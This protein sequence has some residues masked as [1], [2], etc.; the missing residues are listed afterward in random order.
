MVSVLFLSF[1]VN[2]PHVWQ[3]EFYVNYVIFEVTEKIERTF[4]P[5]LLSDRREYNF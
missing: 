5:F 1:A 2:H 3:S 4:K